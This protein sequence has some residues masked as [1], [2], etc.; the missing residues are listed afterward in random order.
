[1]LFFFQSG[2]D[3]GTRTR[4]LLITSQ[5]LYQLSYASLIR[6]HL[7]PFR[8]SALCCEANPCSKAKGSQC[9]YLF[10][11]H[12]KYFSLLVVYNLSPTAPPLRMRRE[13]RRSIAAL[14]SQGLT[15]S[16]TGK[17]TGPA[18]H[19]TLFV[20]TTA[21]FVIATARCDIVTAR[22]VIATTRCV[23]V[24]ARCVIA[25]ARCVITT[26]RCA[27]TT[28]RCA[29]TT[30][31]CVITT[32]RCVIMTARCV[33]VTAR[34]VIVTAR[35]VIATAR[36][37]IVT[38]RCVI[39]TARCVIVTARCV[40]VT[41]RCVIVT[42]RCVIATAHGRGIARPLILVTG[43]VPP[44]HGRNSNRTEQLSGKVINIPVSVLISSV[45]L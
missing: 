10:S 5:L 31:R 44:F 36:C 18:P 24:T 42:A 13:K 20:I 41:A 39:V 1:M 14:P 28:A 4:N 35:C 26:A 15:A 22:C 30:A 21:F 8:F 17:G 3:D 11:R 6:H 9:Q 34:C 43:T 45:E 33:I 19:H 27:I 32:A 2:A 29:I 37:V 16:G 40:I 38:A 12:S 23:I 7:L 25:T